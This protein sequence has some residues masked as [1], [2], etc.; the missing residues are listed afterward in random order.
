[1]RA[2]PSRSRRNKFTVFWGQINWSSFSWEAF[3]TLTTGL[4]A[5]FAAWRVGH[6]QLALLAE[7]QKF[8]VEQARQARDLKFQELRITLLD[9]RI[10]CIKRMREIESDFLREA[11]VKSE[12]LPDLTFLIHNCILIFPGSIT[13]DLD[14]ILTASILSR[15]HF[16]RS[17]HY[18]SI[19]NEPKAS[20]FLEKG[21]SEEDTVMA[22]MPKMTE[23]LI[24][25]TRINDWD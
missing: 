22:L 14:K 12:R 1:M 20:E 11:K 4:A 13:Q 5:V 2:M 3:A 16:E 23:R 18:N 24:E 15:S 6:R 19:Q 10:E 25:F 7:Q 8:T 9:R 21:F 17:R